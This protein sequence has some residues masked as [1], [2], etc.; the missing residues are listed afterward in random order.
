MKLKLNKQ[1]LV[2]LSMADKVI[3]RAQTPAIAGGGPNLTTNYA[4]CGINNTEGCTSLVGCSPTTPPVETLHCISA[5][6]ICLPPDTETCV[7]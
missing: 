2:D 1:E 3:E 5:E 4:Y 6:V 7:N